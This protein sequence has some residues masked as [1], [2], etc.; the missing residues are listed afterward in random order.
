MRERVQTRNLPEKQKILGRI[1]EFLTSLRPKG[2][3]R[4]NP[5]SED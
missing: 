3:N 1:K 2:R 4:G 5:R